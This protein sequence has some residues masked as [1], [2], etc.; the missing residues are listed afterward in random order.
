M[1]H[2]RTTFYPIYGSILWS[3]LFIIGA[4]SAPN[5]VDQT[6]QT[7]R[8]ILEQKLNDCKDNQ[9]RLYTLLQGNFIIYIISPEDSTK[10]VRVWRSGVNG[11]SIMLAV[12]PIGKPARNGYLLNYGVYLTQLT[13]QPFSNFIVKIEQVS[14]DT[15]QLW[16]YNSPSYTLEEL[17]DQKIAQDYNLKTYLDTA[18]VEKYATYVKV[19]NTKFEYTISRR[20]YDYGEGKPLQYFREITG[21]LDL[22]LKEVKQNYYNKA[23]E[24]TVNTYNCHVRRHHID[25]KKL[26]ALV[27]EEE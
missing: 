26:C 16:K 5:K 10:T 24:P 12:K 1:Q 21:Y 8:S 6:V 4:C 13:N 27:R 9:E 15:L 25:L 19:S 22:S 23:G 17:L 14:R 20:R 11:D 7:P 18:Y 3:I 2:S